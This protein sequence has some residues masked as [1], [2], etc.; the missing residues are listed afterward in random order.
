MTEPRER[1]PDE[2]LEPTDI[3][4]DEPLDD[5]R[6]RSTTTAADIDDAGADEIEGEL[7]DEA[8]A[9]DDRR[10]TEAEADD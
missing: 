7:L 10:P 4:A 1:A 5:E 2:P 9:D 6:R 3:D 8:E